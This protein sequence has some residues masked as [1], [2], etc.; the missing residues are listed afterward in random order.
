M[1]DDMKLLKK[2]NAPDSYSVWLRKNPTV[3]NAYP[4]PDAAATDR[5]RSAVRHGATAEA[6]FGMGLQSGGYAQYLTKQ[7]DL[8]FKNAKQAYKAAESGAKAAGLSGYAKYLT[9]HEEKQTSLARQV[10]D[11]IGRGESLDAENA[12]RVALASGLTEK[13]AR[14]AAE[15]GIETAKK[16][17]TSH[18]IEAII[19]KKLSQRRT[20]EYAKKLGFSDAEAESFGAYAEQIN[21]VYIPSKIPENLFD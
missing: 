4:T 9:A 16:R 10:T 2:R 6:L 8:N 13:N 15:V 14:I 21:G 5:A 1:T 3:K 20:V 17:M 11:S 12:Y 7:A 19:D 18:I